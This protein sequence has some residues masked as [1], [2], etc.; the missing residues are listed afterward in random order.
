MLPLLPLPLLPLLPRPFRGCGIRRRSALARVT[1]GLWP[2]RAVARA[3]RVFSAGGG[4]GTFERVRVT[5]A[6]AGCR[7]SFSLR[8]DLA[9]T[10]SFRLRCISS[11]T[12]RCSAVIL[13]VDILCSTR[14]SLYALTASSRVSASKRTELGEK[15]R[16]IRS[17]QVY[18]WKSDAVGRCTDAGTRISNCRIEPSIVVVGVLPVDGAHAYAGGSISPGSSSWVVSSL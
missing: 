7:A 4:A 9:A 10:K 11:T 14:S 3:G 12:A 16:S 2:R 15:E 13:C 17:Q 8:F 18:V 5:G 6:A 1:T